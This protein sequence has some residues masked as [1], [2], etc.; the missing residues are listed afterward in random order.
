[1]ADRVK[2]RARAAEGGGDFT[3]QKV[4]GRDTC[5][6]QWMEP[7]KGGCVAKGCST[8]RGATA[9]KIAAIKNP[10]RGM[11][12]RT[13]QWKKTGDCQMGQKNAG[14]IRSEG[15]QT[16]SRPGACKRFCAST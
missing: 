3:K 5:G 7:H 15:V 10:K 12:V 6:S 8:S 14:L 9:L 4:H 1:M 13:G 11:S 16:P 2:L